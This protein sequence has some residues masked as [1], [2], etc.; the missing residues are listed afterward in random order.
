MLY[1]NGG[2][3]TVRDALALIAEHGDEAVV[4]A[5]YKADQYQHAGNMPQYCRWRQIERAITLF[6]LEDVIGEIH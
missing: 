6:Q 4:E 2:D 1:G 3:D 5:A